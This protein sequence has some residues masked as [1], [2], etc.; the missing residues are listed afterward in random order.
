MFVVLL[1]DVV[2]HSRFAD[3][4]HA[5]S[6]VEA[7][8]LLR[9]T[10]AVDPVILTFHALSSDLNRCVLYLFCDEPYTVGDQ[11]VRLSQHWV[12]GLLLADLY[13]VESCNE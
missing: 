8:L 4:K 12:E 11:L 10:V 9:I 13:A 7:E 2:E 5:S 6:S 1:V 3:F